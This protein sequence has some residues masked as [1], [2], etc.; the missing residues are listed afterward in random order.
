MQKKKGQKICIDS[1]VI[2]MCHVS[3]SFMSSNIPKMKEREKRLDI[4]I[5]KS[6]Y[7]SI[8]ILFII[9]TKVVT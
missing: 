4:K 9:I 2:N 8:E 5:I 7:C 1:L 6:L 3:K